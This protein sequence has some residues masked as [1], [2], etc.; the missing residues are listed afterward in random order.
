MIDQL[1]ELKREFR[2]STEP[3]YNRAHQNYGRLVH[4]KLQ[5]P[6]A[7]FS[8]NGGLNAV[9]GQRAESE[10]LARA[11]RLLARAKA[12]RNELLAQ[13]AE[14]QMKLGVSR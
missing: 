1:S 14:L 4:A 10:E 9:T 13:I 12:R 3:A 11:A 6:I 2:D 8:P 7:T 5:V